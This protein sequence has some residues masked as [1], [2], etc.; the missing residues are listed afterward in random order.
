MFDIFNPRLTPPLDCI[1]PM[2][3]LWLVLVGCLWLVRKIA[4]LTNVYDAERDG[5]TYKFAFWVGTIYIGGQTVWMT[6]NS[7]LHMSS[8]W[9][10]GWII[11]LFG[12]IAYNVLK[13]L[14][15]H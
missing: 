7:L 2:L 12:F 4:E 10:G 1:V 11:A 13:I 6:L 8:S 3:F 14:S 9:G 5:I 15:R